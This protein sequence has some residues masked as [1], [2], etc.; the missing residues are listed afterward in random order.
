MHAMHA[1]RAAWLGCVSC[2]SRMRCDAAPAGNH[3]A[4]PR[5]GTAVMAPQRQ[6]ESAADDREGVPGVFLW[7]NVFV[8]GRLVSGHRFSSSIVDACGGDL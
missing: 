1:F 4:V 2:M 6:H 8:D 3:V 7:K 5:A